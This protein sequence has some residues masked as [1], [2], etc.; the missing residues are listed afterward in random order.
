MGRSFR[1]IHRHWAS[2]R[3]AT[4]AVEFALISPLFILLLVG[5]LA[6]GIYFGASHS[7]QQIAADAARAAVAGLDTDERQAIVDRY[8]DAYGS[9]YPLVDAEKLTIVA[10]D[11]PAGD[12]EFTVALSYDAGDLPIWNLLPDLPLP[13]RTIV[14]RAVVRIGGI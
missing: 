1:I 6:Y 11:D 12:G 9:G 10:A 2:D 14:K 7:V 13:G 8:I 5:M 4:S 3:R